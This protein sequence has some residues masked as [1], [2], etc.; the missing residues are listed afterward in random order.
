[1]QRTWKEVKGLDQ[2]ENG[3]LSQESPGWGSA[4]CNVTTWHRRANTPR[5]NS[6]QGRW[7]RTKAWLTR[8]SVKP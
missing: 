5:S 1:M 2:R 8:M 6:L 3:W 7:K 4:N